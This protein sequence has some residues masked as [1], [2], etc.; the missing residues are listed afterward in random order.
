MAV[1]FIS[2]RRRGA[3]KDARAVFER[4]SREFGSDHVFMDLEGIEMGADFVD[5]LERQLDG[6]RVMLAMID[7]T[8][9]TTTDR[10]GRRRIERDDDFVR[11]EIAA[12]LRREVAVIPVL[13][14]DAEMPDKAELPE[15]LR[16][17]ATRQGMT[18]D[19]RRF[20]AEVGRLVAFLRRTLQREQAEAGFA[21]PAPLIPPAS[22][23]AEQAQGDREIP[24]WN[25]GPPAEPPVDSETQSVSAARSRRAI[26]LLVAAG[27]A[28]LVVLGVVLNQ[29]GNNTHG[30]ARPTPERKI[31]TP[32]L[33][34]GHTSMRPAHA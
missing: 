16:P 30:K 28:G 13:I 10:H 22:E 4:L 29:A 9:A 20:D 8:W 5:V 23:H 26:W 17:L 14:D 21:S 19:F 24:Q 6:C 3:L 25:A 7:A 31:E 2:Y 32:P 15:D 18:L 12:A 11:L 1:V 33:K 34:V 27:L